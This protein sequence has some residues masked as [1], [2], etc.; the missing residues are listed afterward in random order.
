MEDREGTQP[1]SRG[2]FLIEVVPTI[3]NNESTHLVRIKNITDIVTQQNKKMQDIFQEALIATISHEQLNPLNS[4]I[5]MSTFLFEAYLDKIRI[6]QAHKSEIDDESL[7][8]ESGLL[9]E[10]EEA[11]QTM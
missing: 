6:L 11:T 2:Y 8:I 10:L 5:N 9:E 4:I 3:F 1:T 7:L